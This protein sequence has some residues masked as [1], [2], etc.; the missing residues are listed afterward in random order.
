MSAVHAAPLS[1]RGQCLPACS[2]CLIELKSAPQGPPLFP[3]LHFPFPPSSASLLSV[4]SFQCS[5]LL[6]ISRF[7]S[8]P[9]FLIHSP[10]LLFY[11][12]QFRTPQAQ[13]VHRGQGEREGAGGAT[14]WWLAPSLCW[15]ATPSPLIHEGGTPEEGNHGSKGTDRAKRPEGR[16][17]KG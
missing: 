2:C 9:L 6:F 4:P 10:F 1:L 16:A 5:F 17:G 15:A 11:S 3:F 12:L 14:G 8:S 13:R 7:L